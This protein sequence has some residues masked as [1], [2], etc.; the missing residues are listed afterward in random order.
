MENRPDNK[1][2]AVE[3]MVDAIARFLVLVAKD[4]A[5]DAGSEAKLTANELAKI[6]KNK[7]NAARNP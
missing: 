1:E 3:P 2:I 5:K 4:L 6:I 7:H